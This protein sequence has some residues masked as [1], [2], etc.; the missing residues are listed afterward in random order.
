MLS[1]ECLAPKK[2]AV[3]RDPLSTSAEAKTILF[4]DLTEPQLF[5]RP[6]RHPRVDQ[7]VN[8]LPRAFSAL[9]ALSFNVQAIQCDS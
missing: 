2:L 6:H 4:H 7:P 1:D 3:R 5:V 9:I 8:L